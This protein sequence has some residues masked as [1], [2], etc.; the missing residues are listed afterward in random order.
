MELDGGGAVSTT[1]PGHGPVA[2]SVYP[3]EIAI[4]PGDEQPHGSTHNRLAAKVLSVTAIGNRVRVSLAGP[5]PIAAEIT[6]D[7]AERLGL[8]PGTEVTAAWKAT[9]TRVV[10]N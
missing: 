3:W 7:S 6:L 4:E 2:V 5:Q 9:A 1:D 10:G 8:R